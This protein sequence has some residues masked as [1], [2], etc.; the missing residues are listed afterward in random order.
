MLKLQTIL[1]QAL[2]FVKI[3][4]SEMTFEIVEYLLSDEEFYLLSECYDR[5]ITEEEDD[6]IVGMYNFCV[7][8]IP[9]WQSILDTG[10]EPIYANKD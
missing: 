1:D 9:I 3:Y 4:Q 6:W 10:E 7:T 5:S 2:D 8:N